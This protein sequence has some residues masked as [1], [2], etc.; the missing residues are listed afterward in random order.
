MKFTDC[1]ALRVCLS[2]FVPDLE[3]ALGMEEVLSD[4]GTTGVMVFLESMR[5]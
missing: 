3:V 1:I 2:L 4:K 5:P